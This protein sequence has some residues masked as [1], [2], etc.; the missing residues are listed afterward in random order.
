MA[1]HRGRSLAMGEV[2]GQGLVKGYRD[3]G[4]GRGLRARP[5]DVGV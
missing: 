3:L 4:R 5:A 1:D 2:L